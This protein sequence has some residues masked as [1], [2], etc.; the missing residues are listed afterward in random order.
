MA[1]AGEAQR[2]QVRIFGIDIVTVANV[3]T[4]PLFLYLTSTNLP[5]SRRA[6]STDRMTKYCPMSDVPAQQ[7]RRR[8]AQV[9]AHLVDRML[10]ERS[11]IKA[12]EKNKTKELLKEVLQEL[13][14]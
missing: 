1:R 5:G 13:K 7:R 11:R 4:L 10:K 2:E 6:P 12:E 9:M 3:V 14:Q 8:H